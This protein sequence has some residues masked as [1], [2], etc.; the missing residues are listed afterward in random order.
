MAF[1]SDSLRDRI[2]KLCSHRLF[3]YVRAVLRGL[4]MALLYLAMAVTTVA[5]FRQNYNLYIEGLLPP[6]VSTV[7]EL[8]FL[9]FALNTVLLTFAIYDKRAHD[10]L[11]LQIAAEETDAPAPL[12]AAPI[13]CEAATVILLFSLSRASHLFGGLSYLTAYGIPLPWARLALVI[14]FA[15]ATVLLLRFARG[16]AVRFWEDIPQRVEKKAHFWQSRGAQKERLLSKRR[17][18]ARVLGYWLL[19]LCVAAIVPA[20]IPVFKLALE[21]G[22]LAFVAIPAVP[23]LVGLFF[24]SYYLRA[25]RK[26]K[27]FVKKLKRTAAANRFRL[28][29]TMHPWRSVFRD[30]K[31]GGYDFLLTAGKTVYA[32][33]MLAGVKK[34]NSVYLAEDGTAE[35]VLA[36]H[37]PTQRIVVRGRFA[38]GYNNTADSRD[39]ELFRYVRTFDYRFSAPVGAKKILIFNPVPL[40]VYHKE[41]SRVGELDNGMTVGEY[42]IYT[43]GAFLRML[44]RSLHGDQ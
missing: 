25:L 9:G 43:G 34:T 17:F 13:W 41:T 44:E 33:R 22:V 10:A 24:L 28:S 8:A 11:L 40:K 19:Y 36:I 15:I 29:E 5:V 38:Q 16:E 39:R 2:T 30:G 42:Q 18:L 14:A 26:R 32:C 20:V 27:S 12:P 37:T 1:D 23:I 35:R 6:F 31:H 7:C 21:L 4:A 3:P